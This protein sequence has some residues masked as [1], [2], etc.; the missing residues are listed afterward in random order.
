MKKIIGIA[1]IVILV[2]ASITAWLLFAPATKFT[3]SSRY[4]YVRERPSAQEQI[5]YQLDTGNI[6]RSTSLFNFLAKQSKAWQRIKPGRFL[7]K[8]G[9]SNF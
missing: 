6:I 1:A 7:K 2:I 9:E 4:V 8:K 3:G 5:M